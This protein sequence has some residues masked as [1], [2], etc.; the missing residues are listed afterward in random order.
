MEITS[1]NNLVNIDAYVNQVHQPNRADRDEQSG[2]AA[3][4]SDTVEI[5]ESAKRIQEAK[6]ELEK[7]P[8]TR[9]DRIAEL[10]NQIE[11]GTYQVDAEKVADKMIRESLFNDWE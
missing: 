2:K 9:A 7:I 8:E 5:S 1:K 4:K 6:S 11:S 3:A 10:K